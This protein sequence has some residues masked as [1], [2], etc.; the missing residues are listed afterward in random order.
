MNKMDKKAE[1]ELTE[2]SEYK[3][4]SLGTKDSLFETEG[5]F[6]GFISIGVDDIGLLIELNHKH[7]EMAGKM[8]IIPLPVIL[9][10]D[11][12]EVKPNQKKDDEKET[13][14]YVG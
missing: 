4:S 8:R 13:S 12:L 2:G 3:I 11:M 7:G 5:T 9:A 1:K 10:I 6:K 14:H